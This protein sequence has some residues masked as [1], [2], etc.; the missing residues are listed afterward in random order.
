MMDSEELVGE[1][2]RTHDII[3]WHPEGTFSELKQRPLYESIHGQVL[4]A[5]QG[6]SRRPPS[7]SSFEAPVIF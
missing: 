6:S 4:Q 5:N 2:Y 3:M 1:Q 7:V